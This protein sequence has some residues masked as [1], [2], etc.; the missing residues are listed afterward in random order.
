MK[1]NKNLAL[2]LSLLVIMGITVSGLSLMQKVLAIVLFLG[3]FAFWKR[4]VIFYILANR[5]IVTE[6]PGEWEKA[7]PLYQ[8]ALRNGLAPGLV[9]PAASMYLQ[10]GDYREGKRILER[11]LENP[12]KTKDPTLVP[13]TKTMLSMAYW[14][15]GDLD[16]AIATVKEVYD[17]GYKDKNL[18]IN[19]GTYV[20]EKG[21]LKK[22]RTLAKEAKQFEQSSPGIMDNKGWLYIL[23]GKWEQAAVLY[24][25]LETRAPRFPEPYVHGAQAMIH[26]GKVGEALALLDRALETRFSNTSGMQ[27]ETIRQLRDRLADF[28]T[29]RAAAT[30]IDENPALVAS[31][32]LPPKT[33]KRFPREE[34][35]FLEGFADYPLSELPERGDEEQEDDESPRTELTA[36]DLEYARTHGLE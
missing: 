26:Y 20:L 30:E 9:V 2:W 1:K 3:A 29:R 22:A 28:D 16:K 11:L 36:E 21:D 32:K 34:G 4:A 12:G 6:D 10:R 17:G 8:K 7:W 24:R 13:V 19:Y 15:E 18:Y 31:G 5:H 25:D 14:I 33:G 23:E 35:T 27:K